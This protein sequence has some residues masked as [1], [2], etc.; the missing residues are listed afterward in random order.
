MSETLTEQ[1]I[2]EQLELRKQRFQQVVADIR[3]LLKQDLENF[4]VR[5]TKRAFLSEPSVAEHMSPEGVL[6]LRQEAQALGK[7]EAGRAEAA[8][9]DIA[10]WERGAELPAATKPRELSEVPAV[11]DVVKAAEAALV[12]FLKERGFTLEQPPVY[13]P[14][15]FFV[16]GLYMPGLNEHYWRIISEIRELHEQRR[17]LAAKASRER[18]QA[19]WDAAET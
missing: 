6:K 1:E 2:T 9:S 16:A 3:S 5:E 10:L 17:G 12:A 14:P 13:R 4:A 18:L 19:L 11:W 8:L 15:A 7:R